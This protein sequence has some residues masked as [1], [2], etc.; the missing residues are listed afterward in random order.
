[1]NVTVMATTP[2]SRNA[3]NAV[4]E[5]LGLIARSNVVAPTI[6]FESI[7]KIGDH[8]GVASGGSWSRS[9]TTGSCPGPGL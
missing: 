4:E 3:E 5:R 1:M 6:R 7:V 2:V 9:V 8:W